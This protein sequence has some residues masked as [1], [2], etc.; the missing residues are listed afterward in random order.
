MNQS[1]DPAAS[2]YTHFNP[3]TV[4]PQEVIGT[5]FL[6]LLNIILLLALLRL[7]KQNRDL[8]QRI[9]RLE[10]HQSNETAV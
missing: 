8:A 4:A 1:T 7:Q 10:A 9:A 6:G 5:L 2:G 3:V